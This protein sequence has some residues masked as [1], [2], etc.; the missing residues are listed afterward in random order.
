MTD[1]ELALLI[2]TAVRGVD[3]VATVYSALPPLAR[4]ALQLTAGTAPLPLVALTRKDGVLTVTVNVGVSSI[5]APPTAAAAAT[6]THAVL[7][8]A[9]LPN[10]EVIVR[11]SRVH[12]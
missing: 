9:G 8:A 1:D 5:Q 2:E 3:G 7:D 6:A 12:D 11:V 10:A 4:S